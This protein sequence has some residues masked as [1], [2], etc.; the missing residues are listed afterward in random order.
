MMIHTCPWSLRLMWK[1]SAGEPKGS[2]LIHHYNLNLHYH[3]HTSINNNS[4]SNRTSTLKFNHQPIRPSTS[5][6]AIL[7]FQMH[8]N[9]LGHLWEEQ[10][11]ELRAE[12]PPAD[13][14]EQCPNL[15]RHYLMDCQILNYKME[16]HSRLRKQHRK[17]M[18]HNLN[19]YFK[20]V[21]PSHKTELYSP[22]ENEVG[23]SRNFE[24][25]TLQRN[26][27][28]SLTL[29]ILLSLQDQH[30][31]LLTWPM[32]MLETWCHQPHLWK[33]QMEGWHQPNV[34]L[35][36]CT[37]T[38]FGLMMAFNNK[39]IPLMAVSP[40][41]CPTPTIRIIKSTRPLRTMKVMGRAMTVTSSTPTW[42]L[43][44][45]S[46]MD[47]TWVALSGRPWTRSFPCMRL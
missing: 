19:L 32:T 20:T 18:L 29:S 30:H 31:Q 9:L 7:E 4:K 6:S 38:W 5:N 28:H 16:V 3:H 10:D 14:W 46:P 43:A 34:V 36:W 33:N 39:K 2:N 15:K 17:A 41:G 24:L 27:I 42:E 22:L 11:P 23:H 13:H 44:T 8:F 45:P 12:L 40:S 21:G 1:R 25:Y 35:K 26:R 37:T 47:I